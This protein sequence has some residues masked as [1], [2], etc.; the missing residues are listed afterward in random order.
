MLIKLRI[1]IIKNASASNCLVPP[2]TTP[3]AKSLTSSNLRFPDFEPF[4]IS[5]YYQ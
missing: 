2:V 1:S 5:S 3:A 4:P